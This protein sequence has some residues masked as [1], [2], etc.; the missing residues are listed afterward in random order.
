M[1]GPLSDPFGG[2]SWQVTLGN[3]PGTATIRGSWTAV[4]WRST[5]LGFSFGSNCSE[6]RCDFSYAVGQASTTAKTRIPVFL[7][8]SIGPKRNH[9]GD[10]ITRPD[11][12]V[13]VQTA[14]GYS[15][16]ITYTVLDQ[17]RNP[18]RI[19]GM[20]AQERVLKVSS[21]PSDIPGD[22]FIDGVA[23]SSDGVFFDIMAFFRDT[24]PPPPSGSFLK[25]KQF[26]SIRIRNSL[27][28][29]R[30]NC[31][32]KQFD[33]VIITDVDSNSTATCQ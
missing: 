32:N 22:F 8:E 23:V 9:N 4:K 20:T 18:L 24:S 27:Y 28:A 5:C 31:I 3:Q 2:L 10:P 7:S 13:V 26:I 15:R 16:I 25:Q 30:V 11:G 33:D 21:N 12:S 6:F 17:D 14:Y 19:S 29:V 1:S